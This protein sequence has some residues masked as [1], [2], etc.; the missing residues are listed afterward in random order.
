[1]TTS[2][3]SDF[4]NEITIKQSSDTSLLSEGSENLTDY[5]SETSSL[6]KVNSPLTKKN[7]DTKY[8]RFV[9]SKS[10]IMKHYISDNKITNIVNEE[11]NEDGRI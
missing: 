11:Q 7:F 6:R 8:P 1:M 9:R 10:L 3:N 4:E 5:S 2:S